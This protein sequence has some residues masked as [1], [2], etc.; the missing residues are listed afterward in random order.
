MNLKKIWTL[1][2]IKSIPLNAAKA[3]VNPG[4]DGAG[5]HTLS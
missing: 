3:N 1:P 4:N 5:A 2:T